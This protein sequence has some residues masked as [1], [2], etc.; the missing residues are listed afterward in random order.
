MVTIGF[1]MVSE[2]SRI[3]V[4]RPPQNNT[5]FMQLLRPRRPGLHPR[6]SKPRSA[7]SDRIA[8]WIYLDVRDGHHELASPVSD[9]PELLHDLVLEVPWQDQ[10]VVGPRFPEPLGRVDGDV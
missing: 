6:L 3:R 5:T 10:D 9:V 1:G 7:R 2:N 4:P 8:S